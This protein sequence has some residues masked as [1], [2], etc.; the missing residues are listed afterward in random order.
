MGWPHYG[1]DPGGHRY[2][3]A[4]QITTINVTRLAP[5]WQYHTGDMITRADH[6]GQAAT[7]GTPILVNDALIFC[8]PFNEVIALDPGTGAERWRF[9]PAINLHQYPANQFVC[10][11]VTHWRDA[12][13]TGLCADRIFMGTN[14][15]RLIALDGATGSRCAGFGTNGEVR[16]DPGMP[17]LWPG[18]FQITSPPVTVG[19]TVVVGSAISDNAR[20]AAPAGSVRAFDAETGAPRW[21]WDPIPR[22]PNDPAAETWQGAEPPVEGHANAW[23]PMSVDE[24][25]GLVLVPTSSPSP[26]FY[27]RPAAGR[28]P[29]R[30]LGGRAGGR[31]GRGALELPDGAPRHLGLRRAGAAGPVLGL[32]RRRAARR[33]GPGDEDGPRLRPGP[34]HRRAV[35]ARRGTAGSTDGRSR[36]VAFADA[37]V[38]GRAAAHRA[39]PPVAG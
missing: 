2:S 36:R 35:P 18:E 27:G 4:E 13:A 8:T 30:E 29:P 17:L 11:G 5:V 22:T 21:E 19:D 1:G 3:R 38:P 31:D 32:A 12:D 25:R 34:R 33:G 6:M 24:E 14:D 26:D 39:E 28:Q 37:A 23:A 16:I 10:R 7:E 15:A 20:V 9:D